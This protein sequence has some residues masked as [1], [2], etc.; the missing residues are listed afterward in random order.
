MRE[1]KIELR[2]IETD[3]STGSEYDASGN[4]QQGKSWPRSL[5]DF[6]AVRQTCINEEGHV[7]TTRSR[8][9][10]NAAGSNDEANQQGKKRK[11]LKT[12]SSF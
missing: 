5:D 6:T 12:S 1:Q 10:E 9:Y 11:F 8:S 2:E 3:Y 7:G 4:K